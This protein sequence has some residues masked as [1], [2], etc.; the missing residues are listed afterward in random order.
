MCVY[1]CLCVQVQKC[2]ITGGMSWVDLSIN[3]HCRNSMLHGEMGT[4]TGKST[5]Q[6]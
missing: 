6:E 4:I 2:N 3:K 1:V 5:E